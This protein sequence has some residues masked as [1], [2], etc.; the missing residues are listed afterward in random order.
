MKS[1]GINPVS[2]ELRLAI[3]AP[4]RMRL[5]VRDNSGSYA[6][7]TGRKLVF[8]IFRSGLA[9]VQQTGTIATDAISD[10]AAFVFDGTLPGTIPA[11]S[12]WE[13]GEPYTDGKGPMLSG[14]IY[15]ADAAPNPGTGTYSSAAYDD[16]T[17][18]VSTET[19]I[20][21]STGAVG[22]AST[23]P[24]PAGPTGP[25]G[26]TGPASTVPGPA[27]PQ[28]PSVPAGANSDITSLTGL[29][30]PLSIAQGGTG[31]GT[32]AAARTAL[33]V[34]QTL[35]LLNGAASTPITGT[36]TETT[37]ST[38]TITIP[39]NAM[40]P[41]GSVE[42]IPLWTFTNS[43]NTKTM[44]VKFGGTAYYTQAGT[45]TAVTQSIVKIQNRNSTSSQVGAPGANSGVGNFTASIITS[46]VDT[47][48]PVSLTITGQLTNTGETMTLESVLVRVTYGA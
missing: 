48:A 34:T 7:L 45:T 5:R 21:V 3:G 47:T 1:I 33:S 13:I 44:R 20:V 18:S 30:T 24:G 31:G 16:A 4:Y 43:A 12:C 17:F 11:S 26:P 23:V 39:A 42:I 6:S 8:S 15:V 9:T 19:L 10:Y 28:G 27:G 40:G 46:A 22:P 38:G 14:S 25:T 32:A 41:N 2:A 29:T 35:A 37:F 36:T